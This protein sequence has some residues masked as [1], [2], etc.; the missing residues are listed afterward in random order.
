MDTADD[1][2]TAPLIID[3]GGNVVHHAQDA[4]LN[5]AET[6]AAKRNSVRSTKSTRI[7]SA[8][9]IPPDLDKDDMDTGGLNLVIRMDLGSRAMGLGVG[10]SNPQVPNSLFGQAPMQ[11][12]PQSHPPSLDPLGLDQFDSLTISPKQLEEWPSILNDYAVSRN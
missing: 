6:N 1:D 11:P 2:E 8:P 12:I 3:Q 10:T 7:V 5:E 9:I 4:G